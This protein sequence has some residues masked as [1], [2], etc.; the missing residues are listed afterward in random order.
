M[1]ASSVLSD[2]DYDVISNPGTV[3]LENSVDLDQ[4][5]YAVRELPAY[6]DVQDRFETTRWGA[7]DIQAYVRKGLNLPAGSKYDN[8]RVTIFVDGAFDIFDVGLVPC[9][10]YF[11]YV[12]LLNCPRRH[13][14]Q[15][16]Q[17]KLAFPSVYLIVGVFSDDLLHQN[18]A[19]ATWPDV[20]RL[21]LVRHCRWVDE[22]LKDGPWQVTAD[23]MKE[24][25]IDFVAIDEGASVDPGYDKPR[26][27]AYDELKQLGTQ[28]ILF[29]M[30]TQTYKRFIVSGKVI[31]TRR[32]IGLASQR[33]RAIASPSQRA[34][35]TLVR[36]SEAPD[37]TAHVDVYGIGY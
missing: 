22:V 25:G 26:V 31:K 30:I 10:V 23:F 12:P 11:H 13:A 17:A 7:E 33:N 3:S 35:P 24:K 18:N 14:L 6:E 15:L 16:R 21:E 29:R 2:D 9:G 28:I 27:K 32:T 8:R 1:G 37:F 5:A 19:K 20:E 36:S 34:T 4:T